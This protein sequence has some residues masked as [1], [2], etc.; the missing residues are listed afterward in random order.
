MY[1]AIYNLKWINKSSL[2]FSFH[3]FFN[4]SARRVPGPPTLSKPRIN[5]L[6]CSSTSSCLSKLL[7]DEQ[8]CLSIW[9]Y[10]GL[11]QISK[12]MILIEYKEWANVFSASFRRKSFSWSLCLCNSLDS[13]R[14]SWSLFPTCMNDISNHIICLHVCRHFLPTLF[15]NNEL[16]HSIKEEM[17][18]VNIASSL[19]CMWCNVFHVLLFLQ[20]SCLLYFGWWEAGPSVL[21]RTLAIRNNQIFVMGVVNLLR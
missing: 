18:I 5:A 16:H 14:T 15:K 13:I 11:S 2:A 17:R 1:A 3:S 7:S 9:L 20:V 4:L 6:Q 8:N 12:L 19:P 10:T 21:A